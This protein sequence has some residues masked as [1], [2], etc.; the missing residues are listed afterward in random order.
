[1]M[2]G[3]SNNSKDRM[4]NVK[5]ILK[6][7]DANV[8]NKPSVSVQIYREDGHNILGSLWISSKDE[9]LPGK[10]IMDTYRMVKRFINHSDPKG[11][12]FIYRLQESEFNEDSIAAIKQVFQEG[13]GYLDA[14]KIDVTAE[15]VFL[16]KRL[17]EIGPR[18]LWKIYKEGSWL[19]L[20]FGEKG[21]IVNIIDD[22]SKEKLEDL[23]SRFKNYRIYWVKSS[24]VRK[25][26]I[27]LAEQIARIVLREEVRPNGTFLT[28]DSIEKY[29]SHNVFKILIICRVSRSP[30]H[31]KSA[32]VFLKTINGYVSI[33]ELKLS[34]ESFGM[35]LV[36]MLHNVRLYYSYKTG[37]Y[38]KIYAQLVRDCEAI[39]YAEAIPRKTFKM[40]TWGQIPE[41]A[42]AAASTQTVQQ[43]EKSKKEETSP[44][45]TTERK[46]EEKKIVELID[47]ELLRK[48]V[49][50]AAQFLRDDVR[51]KLES[52]PLE[53]IRIFIEKFVYRIEPISNE[54]LEKLI[55]Y[56]L[57]G[58]KRKRTPLGRIVKKVLKEIMEELKPKNS[59]LRN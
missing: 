2:P 51:V 15:E 31:M 49:S 41:E 19:D 10:K 7:V 33:G 27:A 43:F 55:S 26:P 16:V 25:A 6:K 21:V 18:F 22:S 46:S 35:Q 56:G 5:L 30:R 40:I 29:L 8:E 45:S 42:K 20:F 28:I 38:R 36:D 58:R 44:D 39:I 48:V 14:V 9:H 3:S 11:T 59:E 52:I 47:E 54:E 50:K 32:K 12:G 4:K 53:I 37:D 13:I 34:G 23:K 57:V 17:R 1:M 24:D